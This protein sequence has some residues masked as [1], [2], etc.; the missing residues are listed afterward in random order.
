MNESTDDLRRLAVML[1]HDDPDDEQMTPR[2][3]AFFA[4]R[5][6][7]LEEAGRWAEIGRYDVANVVLELMPDWDFVSLVGPGEA[8]QPA[9]RSARKRKRRRKSVAS[10]TG[11]RLSCR[12]SSA[13][14]LR[15]RKRLPGN[16]ECV[17]GEK[18]DGSRGD[19]SKARSL[20]MSDSVK[21]HARCRSIEK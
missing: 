21:S 6:V 19:S 2:Q 3:Y 8:P 7:L 13:A 14:H 18:G 20:E 12:Y 9:R 17:S 16:A 15:R 4:A 10:A 11:R 5:S 1:D